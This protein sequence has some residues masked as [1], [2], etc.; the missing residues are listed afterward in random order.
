LDQ[1]TELQSKATGRTKTILGFLEGGK[2]LQSL[3]SKHINTYDM[4]KYLVEIEEWL[5]L[6]A[7]TG[8]VLYC[9]MGLI[10]V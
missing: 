7:L 9:V 3:R 4:L 2:V 1:A 10:T 8:I 5:E 6:I